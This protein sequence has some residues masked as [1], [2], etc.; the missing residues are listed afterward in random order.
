MRSVG[1][2]GVVHS[3][4][5]EKKERPQ[6]RNLKPKPENFDQVPLAEGEE[7]ALVRVRASSAALKWFKGL[8]AAERGNLVMEAGGYGTHTE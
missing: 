5:I 1:Y 8:T 2:V 6:N 3:G 7:S 4:M